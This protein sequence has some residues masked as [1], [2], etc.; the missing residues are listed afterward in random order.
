MEPHIPGDG[1]GDRSRAKREFKRAINKI[2]QMPKKRQSLCQAEY[3]TAN[4]RT[5]QPG[6]V[7]EKVF[8]KIDEVLAA[9]VRQ[10]QRGD[11]VDTDRLQHDDEECEKCPV[12]IPAHG[13]VCPPGLNRNQERNC[14]PYQCR[15]MQLHFCPGQYESAQP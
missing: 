15:A 2:G 1:S 12:G 5:E 7:C 8:P 11:H 14:C 13:E 3:L 9:D 6:S 10:N 4:H